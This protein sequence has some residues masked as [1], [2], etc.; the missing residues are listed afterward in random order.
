MDSDYIANLE[1]FM[2]TQDLTKTLGI[3]G[4]IVPNKV[5][6][7]GRYECLMD[8]FAL[9][10]K[11]EGNNQ[12]VYDAINLPKSMNINNEEFWRELPNYLSQFTGNRISYLQGT[13]QVIRREVR[14]NLGGFGEE[15]AI[16]ED[17]DM[18][19][20]ILLSGGDIKFTSDLIVKHNYD[21]GIE[22]IVKRKQFHARCTE[23]YL[24]KY[25]RISNK[26]DHYS[27]FDWLKFIY[28]AF[29]PKHPFNSDFTGRLYS[30]VSVLTYAGESLKEII[31][32][33]K[34]L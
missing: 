21:F 6:P 24:R 33:R 11:I 3:T 25:K 12:E 18:A 30:F 34:D 10:S 14:E 4:L 20:R 9:I 2:E 13:N 23:R 27:A 22:D 1:A 15:S 7:L 17:R 16:A 29:N 31:N 26:V 32:H 28:G 19:A 5:T 8:I